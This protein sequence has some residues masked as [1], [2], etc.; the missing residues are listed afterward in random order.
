MDRRI[1]IKYSRIITVII[2]MMLLIIPLVRVT[3]HADETEIKE[4][5]AAETSQSKIVDPINQEEGYSCVLYNNTNGLPTS[6]AN[7]IAETEDG[8][9]WI[10][11]Y[12]GLVRYDGNEFLRISSTSGITSVR[13]LFVDSKDRLWIGTNES[14]VAVMEH[15]EFRFWGRKEGMRSSSVRDITEDEHGTIHVATTDGV[16]LIDSEMNLHMIEDP[17]VSGYVDVLEPGIDGYIYGITN[18]GDAFTLRDGVITHFYDHQDSQFSGISYIYPDPNNMGHIYLETKDARLFYGTMD[19]TMHVVREIDL[20]SLETIAN[21][22]YIGGRIWIC[23]RRGIG[24]LDSEGLHILDN[25]PMVYSV[26]SVMADYE[27][28][29]WFTSSRQ[30]VM[31]IVPNQFSD[32]SEKYGLPEMVVNSTCLLDDKLFIATDSGLAVVDNNGIVSDVPVKEAHTASGEPADA[33]NLVEMLDGCR[34]RSIIR[35]SKDRLWIST[36]YKYGL[37]RYDHGE[38][39]SFTTDDGMVSNQVRAIYERVDGSILTAGVGGVCIIE[40]DTVTDILNEEDGLNNTEVLT[41]IE[42]KNGDILVGTDGGGIYILTQDDVIHIGADEGL[43]SEAVMRIKYDSSNRVYWIIAGSAVAYLT[44][45]YK[46]T[47]VDKFPYSNNFDIYKNSRGEMWILSSNGIYVMPSSDLIENADMT[48]THYGRSSGLPCIST[49]NSYSELTPDG[50]LYIAGATGV[51]KVNIE[52]SYGAVKNLKAS[53]PYIDADGVR[54]Y[55]DEDDTFQVPPETKKITIYGFVFNYSLINPFIKYRLEGFDTEA[56]TVRRSEFD[57]VTYMNLKGGKY[58]FEMQLKNQGGQTEKSIAVTINKQKAFYEEYWFYALLIGVAGFVIHRIVKA[59]VEK[60]IS[61]LEKEHQEAVEKERIQTE[62]STATLIQTSML[63]HI[64]PPFPDRDEFDIYACMNP[65]REVGGDF[66]DFFLIDEDHLCL[67]IAD[68]SG[69]GI[70]AALFMMASKIILQSCAMLGHSVTEIL[71]KTNETI[72]SNN[73]AEMFVTVWVGILE[74]STGKLTAAN[75]GHEYPMIRNGNGDF[76]ILK[77]KHG[78]VI[79]AMEEVKYKEYELQL[80]PG[81]KVFVYTDGV[82]E[83]ENAQHQMFG[84]QRLKDALNKDPD[85]SPE[86]L[87]GNVKNAVDEFAAEAEQ[88]DDLTMLCIEYKGSH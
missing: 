77:D 3:V 23:T 8:F 36:W 39:T 81:S 75:A 43:F 4:N 69:K 56:S 50:D 86:Q 38:L 33:G 71:E 29:L 66:Y 40:E 13:C 6:E 19:D 17:R 18:L 12:A 30:G 44:D 22:S 57:S 7:D 83:A 59:Y 42:G 5:T 14:G 45:D 20:G 31:K 16:A 61:L 82:P 85:A 41:V 1:H 78:F 25:V 68:V 37:L 51:A 65:A 48:P 73:Q 2:T 26:E 80:E 24:A 55:P 76:E 84:M 54:L 11:S 34:I 28:N 15:D 27:G 70:P 62:L 47:A 87:L 60:R 79:G 10:G 9:I 67:V 88:F 58:R 64:F 21:M 63:P 32:I 72:C 74:I 49:A 53:I 46:L 52:A 35:D